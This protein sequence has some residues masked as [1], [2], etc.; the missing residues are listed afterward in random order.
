MSTASNTGRGSGK[1]PKGIRQCI[2]ARSVLTEP[3]DESTIAEVQNRQANGWSKQGIMRPPALPGRLLSASS[4]A[5]LRHN[6]LKQVEGLSPALRAPRVLSLR[7][8]VTIRPDDRKMAAALSYIEHFAPYS[9]RV[10]KRA[11]WK[12]PR[13]LDSSSR[14]WYNLSINRHWS[15]S[16]FSL[17]TSLSRLYHLS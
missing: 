2:S 7:Y 12:P 13:R 8:S 10:R 17:S 9:V 1:S 4:E 16:F 6:K 3:D 14:E 11:D 15:R 5:G